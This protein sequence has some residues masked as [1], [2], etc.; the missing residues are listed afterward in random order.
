LLT[1]LGLFGPIGPALVIIIMIVAMVTVHWSNGFFN[2]AKGIE[3]PL[4]YSAGAVALAFAGPGEFSLDSALR[5]TA[6]WD[7]SAVWLAIGIAVL[8]ARYSPGSL[9]GTRRTPRK[10]ADRQMSPIRGGARF[11]TR[12]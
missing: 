2:E 6:V 3:L 10:R 7:P 5:L 12:W 1:A 4:I 11:F 9:A 8:L